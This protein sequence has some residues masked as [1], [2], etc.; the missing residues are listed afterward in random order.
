M[1]TPKVNT[2]AAAPKVVPETVQQLYARLETEGLKKNIVGQ[3]GEKGEKVRQYVRDIAKASGKTKILQS[4]AFN[5]VKSLMGDEKL[6]R[7]YF[8]QTIE[9]TFTTSKEDGRIWIL[10]DKEKVKAKP[11]LGKAN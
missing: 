8:T 5:T 1:E 4:A 7:S 3:S 11:S 6:D 10:V 9:R 2:G